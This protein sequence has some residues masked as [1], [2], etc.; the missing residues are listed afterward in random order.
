M[1]WTTSLPQGHLSAIK[2]CHDTLSR[3]R[4]S[5]VVLPTDFDFFAARG[6]KAD[7]EV[8]VEVEE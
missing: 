3:G 2:S 1:A 5:E 8:D 6:K 7:E 4:R